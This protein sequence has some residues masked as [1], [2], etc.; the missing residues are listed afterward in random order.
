MKDQKGV[1]P[2]ERGGGKKL[3]GEQR[4]GKTSSS[5]I[6]KRNLFSIQ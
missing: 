2:D 1:D 3:G 4:E 6:E 5:Y